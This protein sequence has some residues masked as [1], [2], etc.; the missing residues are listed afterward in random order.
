MIGCASLVASNSTHSSSP[1]TTM[2]TRLRFAIR[3]APA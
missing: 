2:L 3:Q 1:G